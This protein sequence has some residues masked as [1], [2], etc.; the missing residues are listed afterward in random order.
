MNSAI[1]D[2]PDDFDD[3]Q[4]F[5]VDSLVKNEEEILKARKTLNE[6]Q[7]LIFDNLI[8]IAKKAKGGY[9]VI[10]GYAGTGKTYL[11]SKFIEALEC[12]VAM[13]APTNKAVKVLMDNRS[14]TNNQ[15]EYATIHKLLALSL[16]WVYPK[17]GQDFEPYQK[18]VS[19]FN[20]K[21]S[22]NEYDVLIIDEVSM[23]ADDLFGMLNKEKKRNLIIIFMGDPAQIPPVGRED[24]IPLLREQRDNYGIEA[25]FLEKIMR[26]AQDNK[27]LETA[28]QVRE[29]RFREGD[30]VLSRKSNKDVVFFSS[31]SQEDLGSFHEILFTLFGDGKFQKDTNYTK[32]IAWRNTTV[33]NYNTAIRKSIYKTDNLQ[34]LMPGEKLIADSPVIKD[35]VILFNTS[36]E[37]E[38]VESVKTSLVA[39]LPSG[40]DSMQQEMIELIKEAQGD[41]KGRGITLHYHKT[42]VAYTLPYDKEKKFECEIDILDPNSEKQLGWVIASHFKARLYKIGTDWK[43]RFAKVKYNYAITAHKSQGSTYDYVFLIED[44]INLNSKTIERNRIKYTALTRAKYKLF[45]LCK[46]NKTI[47]RQLNG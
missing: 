47:R 36:D 18:L 5:S 4:E 42:T 9:Y 22:I 26:Q 1:L 44:D 19:A 24:S 29:G 3:D 46:Y 21:P 45:D 15:V 39:E 38:V 25:F 43:E 30:P 20:A 40:K 11:I 13:T 14:E 41:L 34:F 31:T 35:K 28:S 33:N 27:I 37:F 17:K 6:E 16:R 7:S 12:K 23:M 10:I 8:S 32:V 2:I